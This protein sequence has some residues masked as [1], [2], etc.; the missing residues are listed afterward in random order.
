MARDDNDLIE[1]VIKGN[2]NCEGVNQKLLS[3]SREKNASKDFNL[4]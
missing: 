2:S 4:F 1:N 3:C